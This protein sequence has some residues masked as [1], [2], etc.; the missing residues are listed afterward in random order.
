MGMSERRDALR[1]DAQANRDRILEVAREALA[2]DTEASLNSIA[3]AAGVGAGTLYRH[4]P[5]REAL[6][7]AIYHKEI[8]ELVD[9]APSLIAKHAPLVA[10]RRW[11]DRLAHYGRL[12][13]G[14]ADAL[15]AAVTERDVQQTYRPMVDAIGQFLR[16]GEASGDF[17]KGTDAEDVLLLLGFLWRLKPDKGAEARAARQ[18]ELVIRGLRAAATT[19]NLDI[20]RR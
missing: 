16:A 9:L 17:A 8:R 15:H 12:K 11:C 7:L 4:F 18:L 3:K 1:S 20:A 5:S 14:L 6:I 10:F 19:V 13:S 2:S